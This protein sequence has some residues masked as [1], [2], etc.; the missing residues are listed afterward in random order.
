VKASERVEYVRGYYDKA[1]DALQ[2]TVFLMANLAARNID[3]EVEKE[4]VCFVS[5]MV[6]GVGTALAEIDEKEAEERVAPIK[7]KQKI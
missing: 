7:K 5:T 6:M 3:V 2:D 4:D 1:R